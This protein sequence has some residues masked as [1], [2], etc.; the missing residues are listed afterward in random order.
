MALRSCTRGKLHRDASRQ[1]N[2]EMM[3]SGPS[4]DAQ[5]GWPFN[6]Q[7]KSS[8]VKFKNQEETRYIVVQLSNS[9]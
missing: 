1:V 6:S 7:V 4:V 8:Q 3:L 9:K 5:R 2:A